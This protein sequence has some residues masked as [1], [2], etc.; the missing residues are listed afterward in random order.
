MSPG[1]LRYDPV[2]GADR[3][4]TS[5]FTEYLVA[6]NDRFACRVH[7][8]RQR[9]EEVLRDAL[10]GRP[11]GHLPPSDITTTDWKVDAMPDDLRTPGIEARPLRTI[12]S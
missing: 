8:L 4:F 12:R 11:P 7:E 3:L 5:E 6:L 1:R 10:D 2:E 9:R